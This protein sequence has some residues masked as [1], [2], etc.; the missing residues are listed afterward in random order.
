MYSILT[1]LFHDH[2]FRVVELESLLIIQG[3]FSVSKPIM[4]EEPGPPFIH[5]ERGALAGSFLDSKNQK[6]VLME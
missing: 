5:M 1:S 4:E 6:K 2:G 3:P